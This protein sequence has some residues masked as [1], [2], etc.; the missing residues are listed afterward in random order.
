M[1]R[2]A[3]RAKK[4]LYNFHCECGHDTKRTYIELDWDHTDAST[5]PAKWP[6][7][8]EGCDKEGEYTGWDPLPGLRHVVRTT[9]EQNGRLGYRYGDG[10]VISQTKHNY[11]RTGDTTSKLDPA[12]K[13]KMAEQ[14]DRSAKDFLTKIKK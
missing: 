12:Y 5:R 3:E 6:C 4:T 7:E 13:K 9:F 8:V 10:K 14:V 2:W 11:V 1:D